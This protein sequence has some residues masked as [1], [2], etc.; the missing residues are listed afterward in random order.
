MLPI[1]HGALHEQ[2][3]PGETEERQV[4][5]AILVDD[6]AAMR[7]HLSKVLERLGW[8]VKTAGHGIEALK[9]LGDHPD[10][11]LVLTDWHMPEMDGMELCRE[12]RKQAKYNR[13]RIVLMTSDALLG[14][15]NEA[16]KAGASDFVMKPFTP[17][18]LAERLSG[19]TAAA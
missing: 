15:V 12:V 2:S 18:I 1:K 5:F 4:K 8:T 17:E 7:R 11:D 19:I 9:V 6:S 14:T 13:L 16:L 10:C 3:L